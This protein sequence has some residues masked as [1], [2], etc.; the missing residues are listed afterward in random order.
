MSDEE[1]KQRAKEIVH[2][3]GW[4]SVDD[5]IENLSVEQL[6]DIYDMWDEEE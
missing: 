1:V 6:R 3:G 5:L 2:E 4:S